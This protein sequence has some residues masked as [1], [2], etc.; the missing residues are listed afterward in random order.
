MFWGRLNFHWE[1]LSDQNCR[2]HVICQVVQSQSLETVLADIANIGFVSMRAVQC[3][4]PS[5]GS[6]SQHISLVHRGEANVVPRVTALVNSY[7]FPQILE[8]IDLHIPSV[9]VDHRA[10]GP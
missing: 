9:D 8:A 5:K 2:V 3:D 7:L 10:Y 4:M 1:A 6:C